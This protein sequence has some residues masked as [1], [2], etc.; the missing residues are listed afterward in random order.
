MI[1]VGVA[2]IQAQEDLSF[3]QVLVVNVADCC[4]VDV[5]GSG[6]HFLVTHMGHALFADSDVGHGDSFIGPMT[7]T[8]GAWF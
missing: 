6:V 1:A 2:V 7:P 5:V 3:S 8:D 4:L